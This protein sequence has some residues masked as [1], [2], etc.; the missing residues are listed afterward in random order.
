MENKNEK[1][2]GEEFLSSLLT[3]AMED[4]SFKRELISNP[5]SAIESFKGQK[6]SIP[7][8][9]SIV[10][11]DQSDP[12]V[13]FIN[14]P[15][16]AELSDMELTDEQLE[17]VAG[18]LRLPFNYLPRCIPIKWFMKDIKSSIFIK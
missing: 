18:G 13:V 2:A 1:K 6:L 3:K 11:V 9:K 14:I 5:T 12:N 17:M 15:R 16:D 8:G 10:V 7:D 4:N